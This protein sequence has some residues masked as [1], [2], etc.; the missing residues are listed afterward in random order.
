MD[1]PSEPAPFRWRRGEELSAYVVAS[2]VFVLLGL[3]FQS[4]V[5]NGYYGPFMLVFI[6]WLMSRGFARWRRPA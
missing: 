3:Q 5:M 2:L 6:V 4:K 1:V